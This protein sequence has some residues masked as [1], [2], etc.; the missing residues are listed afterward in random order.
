MTEKRTGSRRK[1]VPLAIAGVPPDMRASFYAAAKRA[2]KPF[3]AW[4]RELM[5]VASG[6]RAGAREKK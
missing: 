5:A 1:H 2:G 3:A 6:Y 4:A